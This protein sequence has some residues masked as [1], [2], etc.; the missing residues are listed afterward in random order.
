MRKLERA[1]GLAPGKSGFAVRR[2]DYFGIARVVRLMKWGGRRDS[3]PNLLVHSQ[4]L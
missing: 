3:H 4:E 1:P 2:R